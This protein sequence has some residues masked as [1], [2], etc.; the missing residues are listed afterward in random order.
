[1][2]SFWQNKPEMT[3]CN[4]QKN[5]LKN[6]L[7]RGAPL[8]NPKT[9][10][11]EANM[12]NTQNRLDRAYRIYTDILKKHSR[13]SDALVGIALILEKQKEFDL[14]IQ[15]LSKAIYFKPDKIEALLRRGRIFRMQGSHENAI[16]DFTVILRQR[17]ENFDALIARGIA[18]G[19]IRQFE[20]A[21]A[22]FTKAVRINS[23]CS[24]AFYNRGVAFEKL[25]KF[26][27]AIDDYSNSIKL[28]PENFKAYNNRGVAQREIQCFNAAIRD[29]E[30][31]VRAKPD[32]A[33]GYYN[34]SLTLL[35]I[36]K[37]KEGFKL[38]EYRWKT[39]HFQ[40]QLRHFPQ[41]LWLGK[42]DLTGK[43]ILI[44]SEQGLGDSIQFCRYIKLFENMK[45]QVLLEIEK[46]LISL[47]HCLLPQEHVFEKG[48]AL[49]TFD[50]HCPMMSLPHAFNTDIDNIPFK[51]AYLSAQ[52]KQVEQW[53]QRL[54]VSRKRKPLIGIAW[55]GNPNHINDHL[56]SATLDEILVSLSEN[57]DWISLEKYPTKEELSLIENT[58]QIS[59][60]EAEIQNFSDTAALC[61]TLD[62]VISVDTSAAHLAAS[63]GTQ[64]HV[65][66][67]HCADWRWLQNRPDTPWYDSMT[68]HRKPPNIGWGNLVEMAV[69]NI[70]QKI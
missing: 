17:P 53:R 65:L 18:F 25:R 20:A 57:C 14:A 33:E 35:S 55:R 50:F 60:F 28:N 36:G 1:M 38:Y 32:F 42:E 66:L 63:V 15:F 30:K 49:P 31:S 22:D 12:L 5:A 68:L 56:R 19:Q 40:S 29:F 46:P 52:Q 13:N 54:N 48:S 43:T 3:G 16:S 27:S 8:G 44:H 4:D 69:S 62:A 24:E 58:P 2:T 23:N 9:K 41:P 26:K 11:E 6:I 37:I 45:C 59:Q 7:S 47:M 10:I 21:V 64:T 67:R 34:K 39:E 70:T 61:S 51:Q